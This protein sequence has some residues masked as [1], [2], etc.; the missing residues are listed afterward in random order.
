MYTQSKILQAWCFQV[1]VRAAVTWLKPLVGLIF[2]LEKKSMALQSTDRPTPQRF[3]RRRRSCCT[4]ERSPSPSTYIIRS[5]ADWLV[6][7]E[8]KGALLKTPVGDDHNQPPRTGWQF[9]NNGEFEEDASLIC[10]NQPV[11]PCCS[12]TVSLSGEATESR[13][14]CAGKYESTGLMSMGREVNSGYK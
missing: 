2:C 3:Q 13:S 12:I 8:E 7:E 9:C 10:S 5:G 11:S 6:G 4:G 14:W 1:W